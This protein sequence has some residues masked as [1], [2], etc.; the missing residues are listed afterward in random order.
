MYFCYLNL[1]SIPENFFNDCLEKTKLIGIDPKVNSFNLYRAPMNRAT[2][3]PD[4]LLEW[5]NDN[6]MARL[7]AKG[8]RKKHNALLNITTYQKFY[9]RQ[10]TWGTHPRHIDVGRT[11][12]L[13]YYFTTGGTDTRIM[14]HN[15]SEIIAEA[16]PILPLKWCLL[17]TDILHSVKNI[18]PGQTRY[19]VSIDINDDAVSLL[20]KFKYAD[21]MI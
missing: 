20:E 3:L 19:F 13:N 4:N 14:W 8:N 16:G 5:I 7:Y 11:G 10:E 12:A 9:S 17:K 15:K 1:P 2:V 21:T 18:E 6:I